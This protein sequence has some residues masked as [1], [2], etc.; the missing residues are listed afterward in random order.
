LIAAA[1]YINMFNLVRGGTALTTS[2][3]MM[4]IIAI[5][6]FCLDRVSWK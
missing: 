6:P 4:V 2:I 3:I 1:I 5:V